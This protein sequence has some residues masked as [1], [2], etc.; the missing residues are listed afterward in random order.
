MKTLTKFTSAS[1]L[2]AALS[3]TS[4]ADYIQLSDRSFTLALTLKTAAPGLK[5]KDADTGETY[6]AFENEEEVYDGNDNLT[7]EI[8]RYSSVTK[9]S[10]YGNKEIVQ[11]AYENG[12]LPDDKISGWA[13]I[14]TDDEEQPRIQLKKKIDGEDTYIDS[15]ITLGTDG[16][17]QDIAESYNNTTSYS[18]KFDAEIEQ[19]EQTSVVNTITGSYVEEGK[20]SLGVTDVE[21]SG[22]YAS[23]GKVMSYYPRYEDE[24]GKMVEDKSEADYEYIPSVAKISGLIG[25]FE[26]EEGYFTV[27]TGT[28][29]VGAGKGTVIRE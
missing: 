13:V 7:K 17:I 12:L 4:F 24:N 8:Y 11:A 26:S 20:I 15:G 25:T 1:L 18:Y 3:N 29:T 10:K 16:T 22:A 21:I 9:N 5:L 19:Y 28:A 23:G 6:Q 27:I 14:V 2:L